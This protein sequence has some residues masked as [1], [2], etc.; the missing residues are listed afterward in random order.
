MTILHE[1]DT[2]KQSASG[3]TNSCSFSQEIPRFLW[4][5]SARES[6]TLVPIISQINKIHILTQVFLLKINF[7][8]IHRELCLSNCHFPSGFPTKILYALLIS[9]FRPTYRRQ[10]NSPQS[11]SSNK[12]W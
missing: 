4:N 12:V 3:G 11:N 6:S 10:F 7:N 5:S 8:I 2:M 1:T 9:P